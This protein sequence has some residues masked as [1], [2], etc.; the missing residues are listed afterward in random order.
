[1][2]RP[3][4][5]RALPRS[6][7]ARCMNDLRPCRSPPGNRLGVD[8]SSRLLGAGAFAGLGIRLRPVGA[9]QTDGSHRF[10]QVA[11]CLDSVGGLAPI[12]KPNI[13]AEPLVRR[14]EAAVSSGQWLRINGSGWPWL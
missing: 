10:G 12:W 8:P 6:W 4:L 5:L 14:A 1:M 13:T 3:S 7:Y 2:S 9:P 11:P